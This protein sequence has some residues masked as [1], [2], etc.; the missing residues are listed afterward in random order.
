[1]YRLRIKVNYH[2][3]ETFIHA[4]INFKIFHESLGGIIDYINFVHE[5][6]IVKVIG[7]KEYENILNKFPNKLNRETALKRYNDFI[8]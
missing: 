5:A 3:V 4:D 6:Y 7:N 2:D 1:L 8:K